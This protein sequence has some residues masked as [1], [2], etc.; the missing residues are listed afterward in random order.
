MQRQSPMKITDPLSERPLDWTYKGL[1]AELEGLRTGEIGQAGL[2]LFDG[3]L[4]FPVAVLSDPVLRAN[5]A[6]MRQF[7]ALSGA[8]IAPHG[9]TTMAPDL[10]QLQADDGAWAISAATVHHV[11]AYRRF[12]VS[13]IFLANQVTGT[14]AADWLVAELKRDPKFEF[15]CLVD[16]QAGVDELASAV[17][18]GGLSRPMNVLLEVGL[19]GGR[20]GVRTPEAGVEL[21]KS[22]ASHPEQLVLCGVETFEGVF[23]MG[24]AGQS[25]AQLMI[26]RVVELA[27]AC[28]A[29][30]LFGEEIILT[31]GGS[32]YFDLAQATLGAAGLSRPTRIVIRS[33]CYLS[34]DSGMYDSL[35]DGLILREPQAAQIS[36]SLQPALHVW[37]QVQS[38]PEPGL[39]ICAMGKRDAGTDA[40]LPRLVSWVPQGENQPR[41][42]GEG[43]E[44]T[45]LNDQHLFMRCPEDSPLQVGD[46]VGFGISHPCTTFD[47]WQFIFRVD[48]KFRISGGVRTYF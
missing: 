29:L 47:R 41:A 4:L 8:D 39:L 30:G 33:G 45:G 48:D 44:V 16:S 46:Y 21:A 27:R 31:A 2:S 26:D 7:L 20:C 11:R 25:R 10:F 42:V 19:E 15:Y 3:R 23:Q 1:P 17:R 18:R 14:G 13:R 37:T 9:K 24:E 32:A 35:M 38:R 6:W 40:H 28:D 5:S 36:P 22:V 43:H 34:H 12:G